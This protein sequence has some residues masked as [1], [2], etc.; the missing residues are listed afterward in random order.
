M[1]HIF[2]FCFVVGLFGVT[3]LRAEAPKEFTVMAYNVENLADVDRVAPY[4]DYVEAPDDPNSYGPAKMAKKLK[5]IA[6][7]MKT[8]G[9]GVGPDVVILNE[10]EVDHTP[11]TKV[12]DIS[13]FLKKYS[14]TTYEKM[15]SSELNDE[16]RGLPA[17]IWLLKALEDEGLKGYTIIVGDVPGDAQKHQDAI[18]IGLLSRFPI[19]SQ[20]T[21]ETPSARGILETKLQVGDSTFTVMGNHW[22]SGAGNPAMEN[23]RLGNAKTV[24]D[25][26]DQI[27]QEDP[28]SDVIIGGDFNTQYNQGQRYSFMTKTAIQDVLGSQGDAA[29]FKGEGKP[30]LYNLWFDVPP[31]QR[32]SDEYN[33][34]WGTLIQILVT[35]GLGD[36]KGVDYVPG[37]FHQ[38]RVPG[39]NSREPLGL[40]WR[41]TNY[42]PGWGASDHFTVMATFRVESGDSSSGK[43]L[44]QTSLPQKEAVKV[45]F[46]KIDRSKLR[47]ASVL[48]NATQEELAKAMG[49]FFVVEGT[50]SKIRPLEIDVEGKPYSLHSF[51]KNLK[52]AIRSMAKGSQVKIVGQLGLFKG[53]LQFVIQ[54]PSWIK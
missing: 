42:G 23:T 38:V 20:K 16:L 54:D 35:R 33:G 50:L 41:W 34:E 24:R 48:K 32:F 15:L 11:E 29:M 19:V 3:S 45:G 30:D 47:N 44:P 2:S 40:P 39:V 26:L 5:T 28:K 52:D 36:G 53:K 21:W 27:L 51:D 22:K 9:N 46:D 37:S 43:V 18:T 31:D 7:V 1:S 10:L 4:D 17:E 8:I 6:T 25:R 49:E 14:E 12:T 13:E